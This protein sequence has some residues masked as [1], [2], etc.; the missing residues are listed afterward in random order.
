MPRETKSPQP[1]SLTASRRKGARLFFSFRVERTPQY[2][3]KAPGPALHFA[4]LPLYVCNL[5][6][7]GKEH[8]TR[9]LKIITKLV[10]RP[11]PPPLST[12]PPHSLPFPQELKMPPVYSRRDLFSSDSY[13]QHVSRC[14]VRRPPPLPLHFP[15]PCRG[16]IIELA[17][18]QTLAL[19]RRGLM[20]CPVSD[21]SQSC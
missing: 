14:L 7:Y 21:K 11:P 16:R 8:F 1:S 17:R 10:S 15:H 9:H 4:Q 5:K 3:P 2:S 19:N 12:P 6:I 20:P 13:A 18:T